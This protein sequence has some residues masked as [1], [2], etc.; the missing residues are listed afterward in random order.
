MWYRPFDVSID[1][2]T[3]MRQLSSDLMLATSVQNYI[4][5]TVIALDHVISTSSGNSSNIRL[6]SS[7]QMVDSSVS[8]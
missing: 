6:Y 1:G 2:V 8:T 7:M 5:N 3:P 4:Y